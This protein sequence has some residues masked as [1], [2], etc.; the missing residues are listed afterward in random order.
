MEQVCDGN[1]QSGG[2]KKAQTRMQGNT[3]WKRSPIFDQII[4]AK[5]KFIGDL[6]GGN[7]KRGNGGQRPGRRPGRRTQTQQQGRTGPSCRSVPKQM[8][9]TEM[10]QKCSMQSVQKPTQVP[11]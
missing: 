10:R 6:L 3:R 11:K 4:E 5:L 7:K 9:S 8:C 1:R 2:W